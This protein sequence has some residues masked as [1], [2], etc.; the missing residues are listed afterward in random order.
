M[1]SNARLRDQFRPLLRLVTSSLKR[2]DWLIYLAV[3]G[4]SI[5]AIS[6]IFYSS[7]RLQ[8]LYSLL[9]ND[10]A[11]FD[12]VAQQNLYG[13]WS[14][15][16]D[17]VFIHFD[18]ARSTARGYPFQWLEGQGYS[19]G[20]T[21]L[22]YPFVLALGYWLGFRSLSLVVWAGIVACVS[23]LVALMGSA[24]LFGG[25]PA[26][27]KYLAPP[28]LLCTGV[29]DWTLF[30]G[31][32]V[33]LF[34][35]LWGVAL[36]AWDDLYRS[37]NEAELR[38]L[39]LALGVSCLLLV[40]TRPEAV[41]TVM[42]FSLSA[43]GAVFKRFSRRRAIETL[44]MSA[45]PGALL[46]IA[47]A[48]ANRILTGDFTAAGALAKLELHHPYLSSQAVWEQWKFHVRYQ[49]DRVTD[50]HLSTAPHVGWIV[51]LLAALGLVFGR[52]RRYSL[53]LW[54]SAVAWVLV[55][56]LNGQV[57]WQNERYSMPALAWLLLAAALG[58]AGA[59]THEYRVRS[60]RLGASL[61]GAGAFACFVWFQTPRFRDQVWFFGRAS[62]NILDQH[63]RAG[64]VLGQLVKPTPKRILLSDAGAIPYAADLP[65]LDLIGLGGYAHLPFARATRLGAP[66]GL[67]LIE[68]LAPGDR[69]DVFALYPSWWH[70]F[71]LWFGRRIDEVPVR[72]NVICGGASKVLYRAD[73]SAMNHSSLPFSAA[74]RRELVGALD[75]GDVIDE[76]AHDF[77]LQHGLGHVTMKLLADPND[78]RLDLWDA[79]R[80][81]APPDEL[82]FKLEGLRPTQPGTLLFRVAPEQAATFEV[83]V[84]GKPLGKVAL[85]AR[86]TWQEV[87]LAIPGADH[88]MP[89]RVRLRS[90]V[91]GFAL[92]HVW[93]TQPR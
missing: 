76:A 12:A 56:A 30:S 22:L 58:F 68:R 78:P 54:G 5:L 75:L 79:G 50:Y 41:P 83:L 52:T 4:A 72:G 74:A 61:A 71:P 2:W 14:A 1:I 92:Y 6:S 84:D 48:V 49:F 9:W 32:E 67:E 42:I 29:L 82:D 69:P 43:A 13:D 66:A 27:T 57:R 26:W 40:A 11:Q 25:L 77:Q 62:R 88:G 24:R 44:L 53:V 51:W 8:T 63:V 73:F 39:S 17:D 47:Q 18:F 81:L 34:L 19:S 87:P 28:F 93:L 80:F 15:P 59:V 90:L 10:P 33:A 45:V 16:L 91:G 31:M 86:D 89:L 7:L 60:L 3:C 46:V 21:S 38:P 36:V 37:T 65:A 64:R 55:V 35:G 23:V 20:G 85:E 70:T